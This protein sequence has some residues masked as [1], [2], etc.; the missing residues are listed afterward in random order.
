GGDKL[1]SWS[2]K[3]QDCNLVRRLGMRCLAPAELEA[4]ENEP[5]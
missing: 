1:V 2:S 4:L 3:K 5:A